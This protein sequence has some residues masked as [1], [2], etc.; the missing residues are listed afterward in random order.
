MIR[1]PMH[2]TASIRRAFDQATRQ[3]RSLPIRLLST[4]ALGDSI[5]S[6]IAGRLDSATLAHVQRYGFAVVDNATRDIHAENPSSSSSSSSPLADSLRS[7]ILHLHS[8]GD[9]TLNHTHLVL[10]ASRH[11]PP[12]K[13]QLPKRAIH[14]VDFTTRTDIAERD[15]IWRDF[16]DAQPAL[17]ALNTHFGPGRIDFERQTVKAQVCPG[18]GGCFPSHT[19]QPTQRVGGWVWEREPTAPLLRAVPH[20]FPL[21][22]VPSFSAL[23]YRSQGRFASPHRYT[24]SQSILAPLRWR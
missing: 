17:A 14:E 10:A 20:H 13:L 23:R 16:T 6:R 3:R 24:L 18:E 5:S 19:K 21:F 15:P 4:Y 22:V 9:S 7:S 2:L 1:T 12:T 11:A 8:V